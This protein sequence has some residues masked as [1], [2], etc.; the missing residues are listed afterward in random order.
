[1]INPRE[2]MTKHPGATYFVP[3]Y[4]MTTE[5]LELVSRETIQF[6]KG[7][8]DDPNVFRQRG[9]MTETL[10]ETCLQYLNDVQFGNLADEDT[11]GAIADIQS[12]LGKLAARAEKRKARGVQQTYKP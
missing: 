9:F 1:M 10:L 12:A 8:K 3:V 5:G 11:Q 2:I 6:V 7:A 4:E